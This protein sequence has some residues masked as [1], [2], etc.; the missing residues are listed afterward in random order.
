M[1]LTSA[2][3]VRRMELSNPPRPSLVGRRNHG[4]LKMSNSN[5][6]SER[7]RAQVWGIR[8]DPGRFRF[9]LTTP[10][11]G[12]VLVARPLWSGGRDNIM[13]SP[14]IGSVD[15]SLVAAIN[16]G[17]E[18]VIRAAS[19]YRVRKV[20]DPTF[21]IGELLEREE[22]Y[23]MVEMFSGCRPAS[24]AEAISYADMAAAELN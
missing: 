13:S 11:R 15:S 6:R 8:K 23:A 18:V 20:S 22:A 19:L 1:P 12:R 5:L 7:G 16:P 17:G 9:R 21:I 10:S 4:N 2:D 14:C 3:P 24:P